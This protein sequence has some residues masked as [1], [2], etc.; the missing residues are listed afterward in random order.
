M[1]PWEEKPKCAKIEAG[2]KTLLESLHETLPATY[3]E[4]ISTHSTARIH[5]HPN[6]N[7][8]EISQENIGAGW[9]RQ[10][11][12]GSAEKTSSQWCDSSLCVVTLPGQSHQGPSEAPTATPGGCRSEIGAVS[13]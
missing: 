3:S 8:A 11:Q 7:F 5:L 4:Y 13:D 1:G 9:G 10:Q 6:S 2:E 12:A